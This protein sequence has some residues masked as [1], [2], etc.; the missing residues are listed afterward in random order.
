MTPTLRE[1]L[2]W[3]EMAAKDMRNVVLV[4]RE[5]AVIR[6]AL[7]QS[8][9]EAQAAWSE[10]FKHGQWQAQHCAPHPQQPAP[11]TDE[12]IL[13]LFDEAAFEGL[14]GSDAELID[15]ARAIERAHGIVPAPTDQS[16]PQR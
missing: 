14:D 9:A 4:D 12:R 10:G 13:S 7:A 5:M 2:D 8:A 15:F 11:L 6:A 16:H 1:A 3:I